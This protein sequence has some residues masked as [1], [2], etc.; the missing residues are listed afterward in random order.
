ML[1]LALACLLLAAAPVAEAART[2]G[3]SEPPRWVVVYGSAGRTASVGLAVG[4]ADRALAHAMARRE[5]GRGGAR[6]ELVAEF[7]ERCAA[8]A[9]ALRRSPPARP[10]AQPT[11]TVTHV[12]AGAG[13]TPAEAEF[14]A[15]AACE[16]RDP[17]AICL[18]AASA[19]E[20]G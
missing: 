19:C 1:R 7:A 2:Q 6:C 5:C 15:V 12:A 8:V 9:H 13:R 4:N 18:I 3:P 10:R 20:R 11:E 17:R 14:S 16:L